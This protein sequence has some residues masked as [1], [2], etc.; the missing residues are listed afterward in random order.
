MN[1]IIVPIKGMH[2]ASCAS[3]ISRRLKKADGVISC[4]VNYANETAALEFDPHKTDLVQLSKKIEPLGYSMRAAHL[5]GSS[6]VM[7][8]GEVMEGGDHSVHLG[9]NQSREEKQKELLEYKTKVEFSLPIT[10]LV[11]LFM[12][13][14]VAAGYFPQ[15]PSFFLPME[16]YSKILLV[17]S[18]LVLFW[19]GQPYLRGLWNFARYGAANMDTLVGLGTFLAYLYSATVVLFPEIGKSLNLPELT[20][21]DAAIVVTGFITLG[22]FLELRSK[23]RTGEAI[24]KLMNLAAK[25]ALVKKDVG[26]VEVPIQQVLVGDLIVVKPGGSIPV[27]GKILEGKTFIDESMVTGEAMLVTKTVGDSVV[28]GTI[29][30]YGTIVFEAAKV[31]KDTLLA[32]IIKMVQ[33]AQSSRAP[34]QSLVDKI[35]AIFVPMVL[36]IAVVALI[37]WIVAG[38]RFMPLA[39]AVSLGIL[40][41]VS[42]LVIACPC[43]LGLATPTAI[44]VGVGKGAAHGILIKNAESMEK[45]KDVNTLVVDKTGTLTYGKPEV[46]DVFVVGSM[47]ESESLAVAAALENRSEHPLADAVMRTAAE[48]NI[49][50]SEVENFLAH[51]GKGVSG[52]VKGKKY[53]IGSP[54]F[55]RKNGI[56]VDAE[57]TGEL[58]RQGKT[59]VVLF[60]AEELLALFAVADKFKENVPDLI[61]QLKKL[62]V[63]VIMMTGDAEETAKYIAS[64]VGIEEGYAS[65][66]PQDKAQKIKELQKQ[67]RVVAMAGDGI[68]DSPALAVA[69]VGIAMGN[70]TDVAI[71][72]ADITLLKG[73]LSRLL[74]A[75]RLSR[76]TLRTIRQNLFWAFV[77]NIVGIPLAA[78]AF[79]A[80]FGWLL[81]PAFAGAAMALSSVSVVLNSLRLKSIK[82]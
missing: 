56:Q 7:P 47:S 81:S 34:I 4:D 8:G 22:K 43:A 31:G 27:D 72:T 38:S 49:P 18:T 40:C 28:G 30:K 17:I 10:F 39:D 35:S 6:H 13:W 5:S 12:M 62:G 76:A 52:M 73:D 26:E 63:Q 77:Y 3:V 71:E 20:F 9:L 50:V 68:N 66:L 2:C 41:F 64:Q 67:G 37:L 32:H 19:I 21:F 25:T 36:A 57:K 75:F 61:R 11:F 78:G 70:G 55:A 79:Y 14:E 69:D 42:V 29:N 74:G 45:L 80:F 51:E 24:E 82:L 58:G 46:T 1:K 48:K 54:Q 65:L 53:F 44:I 16:L 33:D 15:I 59:P 60:N 23:I